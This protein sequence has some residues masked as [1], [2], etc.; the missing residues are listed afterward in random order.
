[1]NASGDNFEIDPQAAGAARMDAVAAQ[2]DHAGQT[3]FSSRQVEFPSRR[4]LRQA[5]EQVRRRA[6]WRLFAGRPDS[7]AR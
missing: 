7:L 6:W 2:G 5:T 1:M 3:D 4:W